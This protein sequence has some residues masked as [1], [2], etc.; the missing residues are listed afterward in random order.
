[1]TYV[2]GFIVP[3]RKAKLERYWEIATMCSKI[4]L[5][6]GALEYAECVADDAPVGEVTS[7]PRAVICKD[8]EIPVF[9]WI[10]YRDRAHRDAVNSEV[11]ADPRFKDMQGE[12]IFEGKRMVYG[13]FEQKVYATA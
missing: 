8:D 6:H 4:W 13:G 11:M 9:S 10:S 5:E 7:F 2:D 3:V 12:E 1:M